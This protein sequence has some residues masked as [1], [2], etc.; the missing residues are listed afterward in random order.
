MFNFLSPFCYVFRLKPKK[1]LFQEWLNI[2]GTRL[3]LLKPFL[4]SC[5]LPF[6]MQVCRSVLYGDVLIADTF[7]VSSFSSCLI[8][9]FYFMYCES[10]GIKSDTHRFVG[11]QTNYAVSPAVIILRDFRHINQFTVTH[12]RLILQVIFRILANMFQTD[13]FVSDQLNISFS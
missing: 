8:Y 11:F 6:N 2:N 9:S 5:Y 10:W 13:S 3:K 4:Y 12:G 1:V 7:Q